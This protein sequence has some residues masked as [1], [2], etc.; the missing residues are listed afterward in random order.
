MPGFIGQ[1]DLGDGEPAGFGEGRRG[2]RNRGHRQVDQVE[3]GLEAGDA[4]GAD[5]LVEVL[6]GDGGLKNVERRAQN[7]ERLL[8]DCSAT[9]RSPFYVLRS[10]FSEPER[11]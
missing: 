9:R 2:D 7:A 3:R 6:R 5:E 10:T 8:E 4:P 1:G 11:R